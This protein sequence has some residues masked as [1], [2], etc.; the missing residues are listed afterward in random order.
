MFHLE[1]HTRRL[2]EVATLALAGCFG[3]TANSTTAAEI[4][5]EVA[6]ARHLQDGEEFQIPLKQLIDHGRNLFTAVWTIEEGGGRPFTK[7]TGAALSD[8]NSPLLFPRN[9]NRISGPDANSCARC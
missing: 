4:G 6:I 5:R 7:G 9:F 1:S 2:V 8:P 3:V